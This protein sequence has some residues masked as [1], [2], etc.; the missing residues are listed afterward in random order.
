MEQRH[1]TCGV[2]RRF[3]ALTPEE[4]L[5]FGMERGACHRNAPWPI[6]FYQLEE[7]EPGAYFAL[8]DMARPLVNEDDLACE[9][10]CPVAVVQ[11]SKAA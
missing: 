11:A 9:G 2:C 10:F 3:R 4:A 7:A 8:Y 6:P 5:S 1:E